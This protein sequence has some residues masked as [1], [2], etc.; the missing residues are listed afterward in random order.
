MPQ[1]Q[2]QSSASLQ[3]IPR[4]AS[5]MSS[6]MSY[7]TIMGYE[8]NLIT[9]CMRYSS[10][11]PSRVT[12]RGPVGEAGSGS[13]RWCWHCQKV[14]MQAWSKGMSSPCYR[15]RRDDICEGQ[16]FLQRPK[17]L[18]TPPRSTG[19]GRK[20]RIECQSHEISNELC[21]LRSKLYTT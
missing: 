14:T 5:K 12:T 1:L 21:T 3:S 18:Q 20:N 17:P 8:K 11:T 9:N 2:L 4:K 15:C 6:A 16:E 10:T 13:W 7:M 19:K